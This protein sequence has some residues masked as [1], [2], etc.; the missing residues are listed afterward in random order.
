MAPGVAT[1]STTNPATPATS[2]AAA[3]ASGVTTATAA[4]QAQA[5]A[6]GAQADVSKHLDAIS[7]I[8]DKSTT[9][10]LTKT[11]TAELKKHFAE[12]RVLLAK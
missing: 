1:G 9:G 4:D 12:L 2:P 3:A 7:A 6:A 11:Q 5:P 10:T 8:L